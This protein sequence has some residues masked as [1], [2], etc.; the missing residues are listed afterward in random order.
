MHI[1]T[2]DNNIIFTYEKKPQTSNTATVKNTKYYLDD[3]QGL[4]ALLNDHELKIE[5]SD[6]DNIY[7]SLEDLQKHKGN[8]PKELNITGRTK[9][10]NSIHIWMKNGGT[11]IYCT[12]DQELINLTYA[13]EKYATERKQKWY[14]TS[15]SAANAKVNIVFMLIIA[16]ALWVYSNYKGEIFSYKFWLYIIGFWMLVWVYGEM[17]SATNSRMELER[18]HET[19]FYNKNKDKIFFGI[20]MAI[21][22]SIITLIISSL[23]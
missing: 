10:F 23:K 5:L 11:T 7:D 21:I 3:L 14:E 2:I 12:N 1:V 17:N 4:L 19:S 20:L 9:G 22:G 18:K 13:I 15:F 16:V 8:N 6:S